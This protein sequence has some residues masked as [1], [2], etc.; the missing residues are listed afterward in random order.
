MDRGKGYKDKR[1]DAKTAMR[2]VKNGS[3]VFIGTGC[4]EPQHLIRT[5]VEDLNMQDI[6]VYQMLSWTFSNYVDDPRFLR[7]FSLKLF[8]ISSSMRKAAFEGK[9]DY[10]PTYLSQIP[11]YF[12][13]RRIGTGCRPDPGQSAGQARLLQPRRIHRHHPCRYAK[14][15]DGHRPGQSAH[16]TNLRGDSFVHIDDIDYSRDA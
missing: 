16:A 10:I 7:R 1:V 5:M 13:N 4:G 12:A 15:H 14:C 8:F 2:K 6:M 11:R 3:R 9:I